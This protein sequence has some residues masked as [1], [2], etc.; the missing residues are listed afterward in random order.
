MK[1]ISAL[2]ARTHIEL[3]D[4]PPDGDRFSSTVLLILE[5]EQHWV[6][7]FLDFLCLAESYCIDRLEDLQLSGLQEA[8]LTA[9]CSFDRGH[10]EE[11]RHCCKASADTLASWNRRPVK[12][13]VAKWR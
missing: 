4:T 1:W 11:K 6:F 12:T 3:K 13:L 10:Q 8:V 7:N 5:R 2:S 9:A